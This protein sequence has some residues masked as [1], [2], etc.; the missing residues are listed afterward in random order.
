MGNMPKC[1]LPLLCSD[2]SELEHFA[3]KNRRINEGRPKEKAAAVSGRRSNR[4]TRARRTPKL[5]AVLDRAA[6]GLGLRGRDRFAGH[7]FI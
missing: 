3:Q 4:V 2:K 7:R 1:Y 5:F 6:V